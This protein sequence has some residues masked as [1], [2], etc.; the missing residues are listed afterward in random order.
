[1]YVAST[2]EAGTVRRHTCSTIDI[3]WISQSGFPGYLVDPIRTG[4]TAAVCMATNQVDGGKNDST[5]SWRVDRTHTQAQH[6]SNVMQIDA[7]HQ[8]NE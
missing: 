3:P 2:F 8:S 5:L 6:N 4:I 7:G 1:M